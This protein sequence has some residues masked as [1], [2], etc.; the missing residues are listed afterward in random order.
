[1]VWYGSNRKC[2]YYAVSK[3]FQQHFE[4]GGNLE[5]FDATKKKERFEAEL[6]LGLKQSQEKH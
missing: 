2:S 1:M 6:K 3:V 4:E 5:D